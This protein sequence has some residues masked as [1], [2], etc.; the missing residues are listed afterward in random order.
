[1][2]AQTHAHLQAD[3]QIAVLDAKGSE[4]TRDERDEVIVYATSLAATDSKYNFF[5]GEINHKVSEK[6]SST[7]LQGNKLVVV[8]V[9]GV[10]EIF[11]TADFNTQEV[12][13]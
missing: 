2:C 12:E 3:K 1:M 6:K 13:D 5:D 7:L 4:V 11:A 10:K 9:E 8:R